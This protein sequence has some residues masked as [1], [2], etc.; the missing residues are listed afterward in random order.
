MEVVK[1]SSEYTIYQKRS[2]RYAVRGADRKW[3]NGDAKITIL[4]KE[5]LIKAVVPKPKEEAPVEAAAEEAPATEEAPAAEEAKEE[6]PKEE[7]AAE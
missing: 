2:K 4:L 3:I 6:A 1:R 7:P 5:K